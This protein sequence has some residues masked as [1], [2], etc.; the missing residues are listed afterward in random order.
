MDLC[1]IKK[2]LEEI[3]PHIYLHSISAMEEAEKLAVH[4][5]ADVEKAKIAGLLHDCGKKMTKGSDNLT[6]ASLSAKLAREHF[7]IQDAEILD[8][9]MYHTTGRE[10]MTMLDKI[11]FIADKIESRRKYDKVEELRKKAYE[12]IDDAIVLSVESTVEY[13]KMR[14]LELDHES[15][16]TLEFIRRQNEKRP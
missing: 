7:N 1:E 16:K 13:V 2:K 3:N 4:Y 6:H 9:I 12:N 11:I 10:D 15:L 14:N 5:K 8:A